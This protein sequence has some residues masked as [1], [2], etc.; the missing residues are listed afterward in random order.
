[1]TRE[2]STNIPVW[3]GLE[4]ELENISGV[5]CDLWGVLHDGSEAHPA[6][7]DCLKNF[8]ARGVPVVLLSNSPKPVEDVWQ[9]L[10]SFG[11]NRSVADALLTSG[12]IARR[13]IRKSHAG[14]KMYHLGP[15][16]R[17]AA[18]LAG[19][20]VEQ[21]QAPEDADFILCTGL[22]EATGEAHAPMLST[23]AEQKIPM[24]C[25]N[26]DRIVHVRNQLQFCAGAVA[27]VYQSLG[28]HVVWAGKPNLL[29]MHSAVEALGLPLSERSI[30]MIGDSIQTD[31]TGAVNA[32]YKG[33]LIASGI[34]RDDILPLLEGDS[35]S[36]Q[37]LAS[38]LHKDRHIMPSIE[39]IMPSLTW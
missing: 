23:A 38:I 33:I 6:A 30:V 10:E 20:P 11:I 21:V 18:T 5:V 34:H 39:S 14:Q 1:M 19:L 37:K 36:Y 3:Q 29:A 32:G 15:T 12:S 17:D 27:D 31:I 4:H 26:P 24:I 9:L 22:N 7:V 2:I 16:Q 28:G 13:L 25:A 35:L 8:R